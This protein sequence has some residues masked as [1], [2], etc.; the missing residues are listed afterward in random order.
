MRDRESVSDGSGVVS[1][2][3]RP[4]PAGQRRVDGAGSAAAASAASPGRRRRTRGVVSAGCGQRRCRSPGAVSPAWSG[5][6][7]SA[8]VSSGPVSAPGRRAASGRARSGRV[9]GAGPGAVNV[10][11]APAPA[12]VRP[13]GSGGRLMPNCDR[14]CDSADISSLGR[15]VTSAAWTNSRCCGVR[16]GGQTRKRRSLQ[17]DLRRPGRRLRSWLSRACVDVGSARKSPQIW[18][19]CC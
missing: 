10:V 1:R 16:A 18:T 12:P 14:P 7:W 15:S 9:T 11:G 5:P 6:V 3:V 19:T 17:M 4:W 2:V 8:P 13:V